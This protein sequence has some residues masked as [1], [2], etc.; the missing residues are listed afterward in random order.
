MVGP[1]MTNIGKNAIIQTENRQRF[2]RGKRIQANAAPSTHEFHLRDEELNGDAQVSSSATSRQPRTKRPLPANSNVNDTQKARDLVATRNEE[3]IVQPPTKV[4]RI[5]KAP[6]AKRGITR[7][8]RLANKRNA[9]EP[10]IVE[11]DESS[12]RIVGPGS[13]DFIQEL[14]C[15]VRKMADFTLKNFQSQKETL[16]DDI[17]KNASMNVPEGMNAVDWAVLCEIFDGDDFKKISTRN[18]KNR[19]LLEVPPATGT[20]SLA[21][22]IE[23]K[24]QL[25]NRKVTYIKAYKVGHYSNIKGAMVNEK[26]SE[27][28]A[29]LESLKET[30]DMDDIDVCLEVVKGLPGHARG[31]SAPKK[32]VLAIERSRD[33]IEKANKR[34][35]EAEKEK[36]LL[37]AQVAINA[38]EY[39]KLEER[40]K[41]S[42]DK[43]EEMNRKLQ[44]L[45]QGQSPNNVSV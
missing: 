27:T 22:Y 25:E 2:S 4:T 34:A 41:Q 33:E 26:A 10:V 37:A 14:G 6:L 12:K 45:L 30:T 3:E 32:Q 36:Q 18:A 17:I 38:E 39:K 7:N 13:Q 8:I 20:K 43:L 29:Q 42:D 24:K 9:N 31:R 21:R 15:I 19:A 28:L 11:F 35:E 44:L 23:E 5:T 1:G 40:Q 16:V